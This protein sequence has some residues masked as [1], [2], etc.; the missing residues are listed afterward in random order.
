MT[1]KENIKESVQGSPCTD[2]VRQ[3]TGQK[4]SQETPSSQ[5]RA[6]NL[7]AQFVRYCFMHVKGL[8]FWAISCILTPVI[9][10]IIPIL[11]VN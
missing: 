5:L 8:S 4:L 6:R 7:L 3:V 11:Y 10:S 2:Y 9:N 1:G